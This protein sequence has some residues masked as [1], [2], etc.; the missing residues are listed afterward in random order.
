MMG[1]ELM[2]KEKNERKNLEKRL[3]EERQKMVG[4]KKKREKFDFY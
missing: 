3:E 4:S 1:N 2:Q